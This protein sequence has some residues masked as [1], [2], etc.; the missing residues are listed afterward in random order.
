MEDGIRTE[1]VN[2]RTYG[3]SGCRLD[4]P[5]ICDQKPFLT[6]HE[7]LRPR[8]SVA[9]DMNESGHDYPAA[10]GIAVYQ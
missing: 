7:R 8:D 2:Q 3:A 10:A 1:L 5:V 4:L 6:S 9:V